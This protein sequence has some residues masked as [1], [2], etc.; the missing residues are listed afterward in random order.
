VRARTKDRCS[1]NDPL[2]V[3][4]AGSLPS[5]GRF[6]PSDM[7]HIVPLGTGVRGGVIDHRSCDVV[8]VPEQ[9]WIYA[10]RLWARGVPTL[11]VSGGGPTTNNVGR[12]LTRALVD[13]VSAHSW[14]SR[15]D[16]ARMARRPGRGG[17][18]PGA[19]LSVVATVL[20]ERGA[21][22]RL[23]SQVVAQLGPDDEFVVVD[24]GSTDGTFERLKYWEGC[25]RGRIV[26]ASRPGT[27]I[28]GG[29]NAAVELAKHDTIVTTDADC[30]LVPAWLESFRR[31]F[32]EPYA[33]AVVAGTYAV[34]GRNALERAQAYGCYPWPQETRRMHLFARLYTAVFGLRYTE[35]LPAARSL[36]FSRTAWREAGGFPEN[37][38][39]VE[40][41]VFGKRAGASGDAVI[42]VDA[43]VGWNQRQSVAGTLKMYRN[44]GRGAAASGDM[45]LVL[46]DVARTATYAGA[47]V[48][49][50]L[51]GRR[52]RRVFCAA[53]MT[54][55]S[56]PMSRALLMRRDLMAAPL[57]PVAMTIKDL[58]KIQ[59]MLDVVLRRDMSGVE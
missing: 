50:A 25:H 31:A 54:Y 5:A 30:E 21:I 43:S 10:L 34:R 56:L 9:R 36:G 16:L 26:G 20:N 49:L 51:G 24:G 42:S 41:G 37:L 47:A 33:P 58:G 59:G 7:I 45:T 55:W 44:Y 38:G 15:S 4:I 40:D 57:V 29:R 14:P 46:R 28:S 3:G 35:S 13:E 27:N 32:A 39:W 12:M 19:P 52:A 6:Q 48:V 53:L 8:L 2:L 1:V 11:L 18:A 22:D 23:V 17:S